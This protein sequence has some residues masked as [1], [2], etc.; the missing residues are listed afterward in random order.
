MTTTEVVKK[1]TLFA[2]RRLP[3]VI[4]MYGRFDSQNAEHY[5]DH[6]YYWL[7]LYGIPGKSGDVSYHN[8]T[9]LSREDANL[10]NFSVMDVFGNFVFLYPTVS[11]KKAK[12]VAQALTRANKV[13]W[14]HLKKEKHMHVVEGSQNYKPLHQCLLSQLHSSKH[15]LRDEEEIER[16]AEYFVI[17]CQGNKKTLKEL[18][19]RYHSSDKKRDTYMAYLPSAE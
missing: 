2:L 5:T 11:E 18:A 10:I 16:L 14:E 13:C 12:K 17:F 9:L 1:K 8:G 7:R 19:I 6:L 4:E 3:Q 15:D